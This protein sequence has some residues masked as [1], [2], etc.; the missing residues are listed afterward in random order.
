M[1]KFFFQIEYAVRQFFVTHFNAAK[2]N[3]KTLKYFKKFP[4]D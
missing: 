4:Y 1:I 3:E 2:K